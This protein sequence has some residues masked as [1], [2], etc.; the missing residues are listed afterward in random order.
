M[1]PRSRGPRRNHPRKGGHWKG[2]RGSPDE[3]GS[4]FSRKGPDRIDRIGMASERL[5][6]V[7]KPVVGRNGANGPSDGCGTGHGETTSKRQQVRRGEAGEASTTRAVRAASNLH[8]EATR[9]MEPK[10]SLELDAPSDPR[11]AIE[12]PDT[13]DRVSYRRRCC[14]TASGTLH[15]VDCTFRIVYVPHDTHGCLP[16]ALQPHVPSAGPIFR[17]TSASDGDAMCGSPFSRETDRLRPWKI[18]GPRGASVVSEIH[19]CMGRTRGDPPGDSL[20]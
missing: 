11:L 6:T 9:S 10:A 19:N 12:A 5:W 16:T 2:P 13:S 18:R 4:F 8:I 14:G 1:R 15:H 3:R 7:W 20:V 17:G